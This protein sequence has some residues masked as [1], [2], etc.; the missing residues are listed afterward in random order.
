MEEKI[1]QAARLLKDRGIGE[2]EVY[3]TSSDNIR[4]ESKE[5]AMGSLIRSNESGISVRVLID[6]AFGFA[7][8][9][10]AT[11]DL[12]DSAITSATYQF[13]D[14]YNRLP[15]RQGAYRDMDTYDAAVAGLSAEEC[16]SRAITLEQS[17][18]D[19]DSRISQVR[20]ASFSRTV[21]EVRIVNSHGVDASSRLTFAS[22]SIMVVAKEGDDSQSGYDFDFSHFLGKVQV[23]EVG[24]KAARRA[25]EMLHARTVRTMKL[26]VLFDD[27][28]TAQI[29]EFISDAFSGE[30]VIKGKSF[31]KG[32]LGQRCFSP[33]IT[34]YDDAL[35]GRAADACPFDGEGV[36]TRRT[37][38]AEKGTVLAFIYDTYWGNAAGRSST[39]NSVRGG[40]RST[41][42]AGVRHL[43]LEPGERSIAQEVGGIARVLKI[44]DIMGMHT[45]NPITGEFSV[46]VNGI[47]LERGEPAYPVR[48]AAI[49]GNIYQ[50]FSNVAAVGTDP[51]EFG[52]VLCPSILIESI[53]VSAQ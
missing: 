15:D 21:S 26:P 10:E 17:A 36:E 51:R 49:S 50:L 19:A 18:R 43:V 30:N 34:L 7:Y 3:G 32:K 33:M 39:G 8:G 52:N 42:S 28:T 24:R 14:R 4:A 22:S 9:S 20:K 16:V 29:L 44:T 48:E 23:V 1:A 38:L 40:Y 53:D 25:T 45:A 27:A 11:P 47:L 46:G 41:P 37:V 2:Y 5:G 6:E 12:I 35:D 31:L 13:K